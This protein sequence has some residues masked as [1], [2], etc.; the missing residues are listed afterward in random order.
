MIRPVL[1]FIRKLQISFGEKYTTLIIEGN[2]F[3]E[4]KYSRSMTQDGG[5]PIASKQSAVTAIVYNPGY[6]FD[7]YLDADGRSIRRGEVKVQPELSLLLTSERYVVGRN[8]SQS[9]LGW[10]AQEISDFLD[11]ELQIIYPTPQVPAEPSGV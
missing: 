1:L 11:L 3:A 7:K 10:L 5:L 6:T 8:L 2:Q 9:E 4:Y